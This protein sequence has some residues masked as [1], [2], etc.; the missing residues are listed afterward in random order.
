MIK[1]NSRL[2]SIPKFFLPCLTIVTV[3]PSK[4]RVLKQL[5]VVCTHTNSLGNQSSGT[6]L[7]EATIAT[8]LNC[9]VQLPRLN[10]QTINCSILL[11]CHSLFMWGLQSQ[12]PIEIT[13][14]RCAK[15]YPGS[16]CV[17]PVLFQDYYGF[18][19]N[20]RWSYVDLTRSNDHDPLRLLRIV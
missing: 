2:S 19:N 4:Y 14:L 18:E 8:N 10:M 1:F 9:F 15:Q 5:L 20:F 3:L 6:R 7:E 17:I 16:F 13:V 11:W 12:N